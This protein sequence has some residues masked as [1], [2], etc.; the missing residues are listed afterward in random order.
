MLVKKKFVSI[1]SYIYYIVTVATATTVNRNTISVIGNP[2]VTLGCSSS[3]CVYGIC[4]DHINST[5]TCYC[6]NGYTGVRCQTNWDECWSSPCNNGGMCVDGI[7]DY[8]CTCP[9]GYTGH[10]CELNIDECQSNPCQNNGTCIDYTNRFVCQCPYGYS[11]ALCEI[12]LAVC[13]STGELFCNNG[14]ECIEGPGM[15]YTCNCPPGWTGDTCEKAIDQCNSGPCQNGGICI[16][17]QTSYYCTCL[18]GYTGHN[19]DVALR[20]CDSHLCQNKALCLIER[21]MPVCYCVPDY[22]GK[23][24]QY[25]Y[26]ECKLGNSCLNGGTCIDGIDGYTCLCP[27]GVTGKSCEC[28]LFDSLMNCTG[29][30]KPYVISSTELPSTTM[31]DSITSI[32]SN[33][34]SGTNFSIDNDEFSFTTGFHIFSTLATTTS[35]SKATTSRPILSTSHFTTQISDSY[36]TFDTTAVQSTISDRVTTEFTPNTKERTVEDSIILTETVKSITEKMFPSIKSTSKGTKKPYEIFTTDTL[37]EYSTI[38][39][40]QLDTYQTIISDLQVT[41]VYPKKTVAPTRTPLVATDYPVFTPTDQVF[42]KFDINLTEVMDISTE[43]ISS[44]SSYLVCAK[45]LNGKCMKLKSGY[46]CD[47]SF[48]W[49]GEICD[50][51]IN[52]KVP[53][54][55]GKSYLTHRLSYRYGTQIAMEIRTLAPNGILFYAQVMTHMYM[56][57]YLQDGLLKFQFSC[58]VQTMLFSETRYRVNTGHRLLLTAT[59]EHS[60]SHSMTELCKAS[61]RVNDT[62]AMSGE[63]VADTTSDKKVALLYVGGFPPNKNFTEIPVTIGIAGCV[64]HLKIDEVAHDVYDSAFDGHGV[65]ECASLTCLSSP[66]QSYATC[67]EFGD[68]WNCLCPSGFIG[69]N[70]E[71]SI[72]ENNPCK[73]GATCVIYPGSGF[74][75][76]CPL[77]KHGMYCEQDLEIDD[78]FFPGSISG[79]SSYAAYSIPAEIQQSFELTMNFVPN[80]MDQISLMMYIGHDTASDHVALSF[81]KGFIVLTWNLGAGPRRIFTPKPINFQSN[82]AHMVKLGRN[83]KT[84]WLAVDNFP[85]ITGHSAGRLTQLNTNPVLYLGGHESPGMTDLPHDLPLHTGFVGCM[86][87]IQLKAGRMTVPLSLSRAYSAVNSG[88]SVSQCSTN[89]C[90]R[91]NICQHNGAC[92]QH[93]SSLACICTDGWFG[94]LCAHRYNTCDSNR[95]SCF[96]GSTCIPV[97]N[98]FECDCPVGRSGKYCEREEQLSDV[99]FLGKRSFI[100]VAMATESNTQQFSIE[101]EIK[102]SVDNGILFFILYDNPPKKFLC[103]SMYGGVIE[104]RISIQG[105]INHANDVIVV[106]SGRVLKMSEWHSVRV[107]KYRRKLYLWVDGMINYAIL[108]PFDGSIDFDASLN[109]GGLSDLSDL[110]QGATSGLPVPFT[111]CIRRLTIDYEVIP[112]NNHTIITGRNIADC[113]GTPCGGDL[114]YHGGNCWLDMEMKPHCHC[115]KEFVGDSCSIQMP[116]SEF[117]CQNKGHCVQNN[118]GSFICIC[119]PGWDGPFCSK[120]LPTGPPLFKGHGHLVLNKLSSL[121]KREDKGNDKT[122]SI[123]FLSLKFSTTYNNGL[124][125]WTSQEDWYLGFGIVNEF[126]TMVW[127]QKNLIPLTLTTPVNNITNGEWHTV[128][129]NVTRLEMTLEV[130]DWVSNS[131][132]HNIENHLNDNTIYLGGVPEEN[133]LIRRDLFKG[134]FRG[135]INEFNSQNNIITDFH[136]YESVN[137]DSCDIW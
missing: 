76:L 85:N 62:L 92:I 52:I 9:D 88:R 27:K 34:L 2:F 38:N 126:L 44:G 135:C 41:S 3:P 37:D 56:C 130:D 69:K 108:Q 103:L 66:C 134:N 20:L 94:P 13:N 123:Q 32:V 55:T 14:G 78:P 115:P 45:C 12:D 26:D 101:L 120:E 81:I 90:Y 93:G 58:G 73:F 17:K 68:S 132:E 124:I 39:S 129:L 70:C 102:P 71:K 80:S 77:G 105:E 61:L 100:S 54:F 95:H 7:A 91:N 57:L 8:N 43:H 24:C 46:K 97:G 22:H 96:D 125:L 84:A 99:R 10:N 109:L 40:P 16:N 82:K 112:L 116:C 35:N 89:E 65:V 29:I 136:N 137:I 49:K 4:V 72:C 15:S 133:F 121:T 74:I 110:P 23:H 1:L 30:I 42:T 21:D 11:G 117:N 67:V 104:L 75:C 128:R 86:S 6:M 36:R 48:G 63:Q 50:K 53:A 106:R 51:K 5:Y 83:G 113:D 111:G 131:Y 28:T 87:S 33:D 114:C 60:L 127:G 107:G 25:Q 119:P 122:N 79:L 47:C 59:L 118:N 31:F 19:C 18:F 64:T 98:T